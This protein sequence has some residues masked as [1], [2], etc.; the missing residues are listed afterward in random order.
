MKPGFMRT[1]PAERALR[2]AAI[3]TT[4]PLIAGAGAA[5]AQ[6]T[7]SWTEFQGGPTK[8]GAVVEGPQPGY[9]QAWRTPI[10][11]GG[12]G[13]RYGL[14]AP[15]IAG[16]VAV[17]T[18]PEQIVGVDIVS[19]EQ[20]WSVD[21]DLGPP[22]APAAVSTSQGTLIVYTEG[23]GDGPPA[24]SPTTVAGSAASPSPSGAEIGGADEQVDSHMAAFDLDTQEALW[25]PVQLD[26]VSR[27][28]VTIDGGL[29][30]VGGNDGTVTAVDL[31][32]GAV[33]WEQQLNASLLTSLA[34]SDGLV[35]VSLQGDRDTQPVVVALDAAS[36]EE[37]WRHEP[38]APSAVVSA[39]SVDDDQVFAIF[40]GLSETS[41][42]AIDPADGTQ[43]WAR[44]L[45]A[46][47]DVVSPPLVASG[48]VFVTDLI[49]HTR[50][51]DATTGEEIWDFAMN[52]TAF[53][54]MPTL[55]GSFLLVPTLE[56]AIGAIDVEAGEIVWRLPDDGSSLR[57]LAPAGGVL[58]GVRGGARAGFEAYEHDPDAAL[59]REASPTTLALAP[60][61][62]AMAGGALVVLA[63][64]LLLGRFL[65]SRMVPAF[66]GD[67][68]DET[69]GPDPGSIRDPWEDEEPS[70]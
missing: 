59:V 7:A 5:A 9:R 56:G 70:P 4:L 24:A 10:E 69:A 16:D 42:V 6:A 40:T 62:A 1:R 47:F 55:V 41:I 17:A 18:G 44:R 11:P 14:S 50:A 22:V 60:M 12:P 51:L 36:G 27:T 35:F 31:A 48:R 46:A 30:F 63:V 57:S 33:A 26:A 61:L 21:R 39:V 53:R 25:P 49:G 8:T 52:A 13:G 15:V 3:V 65:A 66:G 58:I 34:A 23:W 32:E 43:R 67:P 64:V 68:H 38:V 20:A 2:V 29:A 54:S 37:R 45:N 19:G 28:G